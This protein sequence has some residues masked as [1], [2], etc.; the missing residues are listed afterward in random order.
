MKRCTECGATKAR[1]EFHRRAASSDGLQFV[2]KPC[3][4]VRAERSR[5]RQRLTFWETIRPGFAVRVRTEDELRMA[6]KDP[7]PFYAE[8]RR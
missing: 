8:A 3:N 2:C 5:G 6:L 7:Y 1:G 4:Y